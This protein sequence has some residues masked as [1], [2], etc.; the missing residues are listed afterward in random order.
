[1]KRISVFFAIIA[2]FVATTVLA[3]TKSSVIV[4]LDERPSID[5]F[6]EIQEISTEDIIV[7][8]IIPA[9]SVEAT[10]EERSKWLLDDSVVDIVDDITLSTQTHTEQSQ[11]TKEYKANWGL[12]EIN[13]ADRK[14]DHLTG[15]GVKVGIVDTGIDYTH[16]DL[17]HAFIEGI[18]FVN[19]DH[20]PMDD[21]GHGTHVSGI[22]AAAIDDIGIRGVAPD[23]EL[24][25]AKV[26]NVFG[27]CSLSALLS[28]FEWMIDKEVNVINVSL[29]SVFDNLALNMAIDRIRFFGIITVAAGGNRTPSNCL[30]H[31]VVYPGGYRTVM[32]VSALAENGRI[33]PWSSVPVDIAAPGDKIL[34][35]FL[36][37][38]YE[39][40]SGT[41]MAAPHVT[42]VV[43]LHFEEAFSGRRSGVQDVNLNF[44]IGE[45]IFSKVLLTTQG[46]TRSTCTRASRGSGV[47]DAKGA[48]TNPFKFPTPRRR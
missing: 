1:M 5:D 3:Q 26:C 46:G 42:G 29:G 30:R 48:A 34:S 9:I 11:R 38:K 12:K 23:A 22:I 17:S 44:R 16:P 10:E 18:D 40:F 45:E 41:S 36:D 13:V 24:Y 47:V 2:V 6:L 19:K 7:Y 37:G 31:N 4:I 20:D 8:K 27:A 14:V 39:V 43:A 35:T 28:G 15:R 25:V 33:T 21:N 32:T